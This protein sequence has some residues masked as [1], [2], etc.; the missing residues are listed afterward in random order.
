MPFA[1]PPTTPLSR[2]LFRAPIWIY[3]LG[4]GGALGGRFVLL[5]HRGRT[6]GEAR[7]AVLEVVGRNDTTGAVLI[8]SGYG[9]RSQWFRNIVAEPRVLFQVGGRRHRGTAT[10][11][12]PQESGEALAHYAERHPEAAVALMRGLGHEVDG[13]PESFARVGA[14][15]ENGIPVV[16]LSPDDPPRSPYPDFSAP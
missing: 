11:L 7:Q 6:T 5:T 15:P 8:A 4:L 10:V 14:D 1:Q 13:G 9:R 3:R 16:R 2:A 12:S